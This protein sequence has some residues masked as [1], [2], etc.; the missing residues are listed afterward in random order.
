MN[1]EL[2]SNYEKNLVLIGEIQELP[3]DIRQGKNILITMLGEK[4]ASTVVMTSDF[5]SRRG[6]MKSDFVDNVPLH[7]PLDFLPEE[8]IEQV[9]GTLHKA[10]LPFQVYKPNNAM[11]RILLGT[12]NQNLDALMSANV[13]GDHK[14]IGIALGYP[15]SAVTSLEEDYAK[16][17]NA[18]LVKEYVPENIPESILYLDFVPKH[19][20]CVIM[21]EHIAYGEKHASIVKVIDRIFGT[22][23]H[24]HYVQ[25]R[26]KDIFSKSLD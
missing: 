23:F 3:I 11:C 14:R 12:D 25:I 8:L 4:P 15:E 22:N 18:A 20:N 5:Y 19:E 10:G 24:N 6:Y 17:F 2:I 26:K 16:R 1:G 9:T 13:S 7:I 21:P